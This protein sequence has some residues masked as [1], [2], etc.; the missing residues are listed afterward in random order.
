ML[1]RI[2][3]I[4][5]RTLFMKIFYG[6]QGTGN[7]HLARARVMAKELK[8]AGI[9]TQFLFTGRDANKY[10]DMDVF[11]H[12]EIRTGLTFNTSKGKLNYFKTATEAKVSTFL[13]DVKMLDLSAYDLVITDFEPVCAWAARRQ[14][15]MVLGLGNQYAYNFDIPRKGSD[16]IADLIMKYFAPANKSIGM[17]WH[18]FGQP[19]VPPIVEALESKEI[20]KNKIVVYLPFEDTTDVE[21]LL[22]PFENF[23]FHVSSSTETTSKHSHITYHS[24]SCD[25]FLNELYTCEGIISNAGFAMTSEALQLGKKILI[26]PLH[27]QV[28]Q[29]SNAAALQQLGYAHV[30]NE[31]DTEVVKHWLQDNRAIHI[32]YPNTA[33]ILTK[34]IQEGMPEIDMDFIEAIWSHVDILHIER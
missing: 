20:I 13:N 22:A 9:E 3:I 18:H 19:I 27:A 2:Q 14:K 4:V 16:P 25:S 6:V 26:K 23:E 30:M 21:K 10:F 28:E 5:G 11:G 8:L 15:K 31:L 24:M 34:W 1:I 17:H 33:K 29:T 12:Y 7:G 32:T